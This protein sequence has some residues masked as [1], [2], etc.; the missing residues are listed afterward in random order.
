MSTAAAPLDLVSEPSIPVERDTFLRNLLRELAGTLQKVVGLEEA[1]GFISVV[2]QRLG[3]QVNDGYKAALDVSRLSPEQVAAVLVDF[4][5][6]I[7]GD[8]YVVEQDDDRIVLGNRACPFAEAVEGR[9]AL[10]GAC[11]AGETV[12]VGRGPWLGRTKRPG[13]T[14]RPVAPGIAREGSRGEVETARAGL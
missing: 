14:P 3:D 10:C 12:S 11:A 9:P 4:Q 1:S 7:A 6:R 2:G 8:F 13:H 5:R